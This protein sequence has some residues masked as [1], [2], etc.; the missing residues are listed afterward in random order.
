MGSQ[1][2]RHDLVTQQQQQQQQQ[3]HEIL[4]LNVSSA[5]G[6]LFDYLTN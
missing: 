2:V 6:Q 3:Q 4:D 5:S 1:G